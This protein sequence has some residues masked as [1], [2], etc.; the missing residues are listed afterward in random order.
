MI[1]FSA[2]IP[3]ALIVSILG[4]P[5]AWSADPPAAQTKA[6]GRNELSDKE[7][8]TLRDSVDQN[9]KDV[10]DKL[11]KE[12]LSQAEIE[13]ALKVYEASE[14]ILSQ[15]I[16]T[17][18]R[19]WTLKR[20][21]LALIVLAYERT[22]TFFPI[23]ASEIDRLDAQKGCEKITHFAERHVL[24][25]ASL[26][27]VQPLGDD[28]AEKVDIDPTALAERLVYF[29]RRYPSRESDSL[30]EILVTRIDRLPSRQRNRRLAV[31]AP[32]FSKYFLESQDPI[33]LALGRQLQ[34]V[35][36]RL[37]LPGKPMRVFGFDCDGTIF[38]PKTLDGKVVL[39]QFWGTWC[40]PCLEEIPIL[41]DLYE[42]YHGQGFEI[43][44][45]NT[46]VKGDEKPEKVKQYVAETRFPGG[47]KIT[48]PILH[49][50]PRGSQDRVTMTRF[51]GVDELPVTVLIGRDGHVLKLDPLPNSLDSEVRNALTPK[52]S[53]DDL[54]EEE[55]ARA[56]ESMRRDREKLQKELD[57]LNVK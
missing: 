46:G 53:L 30:I 57:A 40:R 51:Y 23:L 56:E 37:D 16:S 14:S 25:I 35:A 10:P 9:T 7:L 6:A 34:A 1:R 26:L 49:E 21:A 13:A 32:I 43:V 24:Q 4:F 42:Q 29:A 47:K 8:E 36:R 41:I 17:T 54:T 52:I 31:V 39:V 38:D 48:W 18:F 12:R 11:G 44:G 55:R 2:S 45:V 33:S 5:P 22:S 3:V 50:T 20:R 15:D 28:K 27:V 19:V